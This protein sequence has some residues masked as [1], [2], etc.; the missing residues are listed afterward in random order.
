MKR[1][2]TI[3]SIISFL[4]SACGQNANRNAFAVGT[5]LTLGTIGY[6]LTQDEGVTMLALSTGLALGSHVGSKLDEVNALKQEVLNLNADRERSK[7]SKIDEET[8]QPIT[9]EIEP[10]Q[11][12]Q[13]DRFQQCREYNY[14]FTKNGETSHGRGYACLN[15]HGVW[16]E[17]HHEN[18]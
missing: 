15:E 9:V 4:L 12:F 2:I 17:L 11:T 18:G 10:T 1:I 13:N 14:A 6:A 3:I 8:N 5:G 7:F 16:Q